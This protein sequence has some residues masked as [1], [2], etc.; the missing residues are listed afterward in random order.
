MKTRV[1][2]RLI[3]TAFIVAVGIAPALRLGA[4]EPA[5]DWFPEIAPFATG[6]LKVSDTHEICYEL[7][8]NPQG[9]PVMV[10]HGGPGGGSYPALRRYHDPAKYLI[11]LHDQRGVG[12]SR[13]FCELKDN[14][15]Q[16]LVEDIEKLRTHLKLGKVQIFGGSWGST[17]GVAYAETYPDSVS[18]LVLRGV[19]LGSRAEIDHFYHG[20]AARNFPDAFARLQAVLP[21]PERLNYP[22]QLLTLLQG[23]DATVRQ[24]AA[25][26]WA[27]YETK[28]AYLEK[29]DAEVEA[30]FKDWDPIDFSLI[31]NFYMTHGCFL[32]E[33]QLLQNAARLAGIPTVIVEGRYD[34]ICPPITAW[35]L[36]RALPKSRLVIVEQAGH[37]GSDPRMR[38]A[39]VAAVKSLE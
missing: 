2:V 37:S 14:T 4:D 36:H 26:A 1:P 3:L 31:E 38:A 33:G 32:T 11:V 23:A 24:R 9:I 39:L 21:E 15:T 5:A 12:R 27:T 19:C 34:V 7:C 25:R 17:L 6:Y 22:Q 20:G 8:G 16:A 18:S 35:K 29:S 30:D 10:L 13:P 28:L